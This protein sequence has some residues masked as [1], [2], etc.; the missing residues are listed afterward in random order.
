MN[1]TCWTSWR[2]SRRVTRSCWR[3][4][5]PSAVQ[6]D[7]AEYRKQAKAASDLQPLVDKFREYKD[8]A[9]KIV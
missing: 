3:R 7:P 2:R 1:V 4:W 8:V 5:A 6:N 9:R